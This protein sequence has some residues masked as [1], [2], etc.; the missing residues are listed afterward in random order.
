MG[1][2]AGMCS[3]VK[4]V[5][6][7]FCFPLCVYYCL[8]DRFIWLLVCLLACL[9]VSP[10]LFGCAPFVPQIGLCVLRLRASHPHGALWLQNFVQI[11][12]L[13][14]RETCFKPKSFGP[15][16]QKSLNAPKMPTP[17]FLNPNTQR[18]C[19]TAGTYSAGLKVKG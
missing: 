8:I 3:W 14:D 7:C 13:R 10:F 16:T 15:L 18:K 17:D 12:S 11:F 2:K 1:P 5:L 6:S 9:F 19:R 4:T